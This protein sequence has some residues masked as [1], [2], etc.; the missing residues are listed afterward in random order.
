MRARDQ[1]LVGVVL[2]VATW[3]SLLR[4]AESKNETAVGTGVFRLDEKHA[5]EMAAFRRLQTDLAAMGQAKLS[6]RLE[7]L[8][9]EDR[10]WVAPGLGP[11]QW[12]VF[13]ESLSLV[14]RI[15]I[16][17]Q[18]LVDPILHL[19][20]TPRNDVPPAHKEAFARLSLGGALVHEM[21][22]HDGMDESA[23]YARELAWYQELERAPFL[24]AL[25]EAEKRAFSWA[26]E[27]ATRSARKAAERAGGA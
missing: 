23:A 27:A 19:Y 25:P 9:Q 3:F 5:E 7:T 10:L 17:R 2:A 6:E 1:L 8:R 21:A 20:P 14:R 18:A 22:H 24:D 11:E 15:Y 4:I 16:R 12:A 13:V 26:L